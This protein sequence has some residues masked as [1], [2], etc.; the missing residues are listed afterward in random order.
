[1]GPEQWYVF[2]CYNCKCRNLLYNG[3][4]SDDG[5]PDIEGFNC[6]ECKAINRIDPGTDT[7][8][9]EDTYVNYYEGFPAP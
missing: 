1:M 6:Y 5:W 4:V 2:T 7:W 8:T 3:P 9:M